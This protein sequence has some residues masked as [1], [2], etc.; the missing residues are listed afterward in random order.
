VNHQQA[1]TAIHLAWRATEAIIDHLAAR[2]GRDEAARADE[3][4]KRQLVA[5]ELVSMRAEL[6]A[7][8]EL[9]AHAKRVGKN[10]K[11][12]QTSSSPTLDEALAELFAAEAIQSVM[13]RIGSRVAH[14]GLEATTLSQNLHSLAIATFIDGVLSPENYER[15]AD[16]LRSVGHAGD[17]GLD[18]EQQLYRE[19]FKRYAEEVVMPLADKIHR[20]DTDIPAAIIDGLRELGCFGLSIP[21]RYGGAQDDARPNHM[22]M[23][24]VTEELSRASLGAAGSLITRP[25]IVAKAILTGGAEAQKQKWLP[26]IASGEKMVA[27]AVTEPDFGSDVAG[28]K[29]S[30]TPVSGGYLVNGTKT[31][32]TFG[33]YADLLLVLARTDPDLSK[34]HRGLSLLLVEKSRCAGH[35]FEHRQPER[36]GVIKGAAMRT[37]GYRGMHSFEINFVDYFVPE[38]NLI[39]GKDGLGKGFYLQ[40]AGFASGRLQTAA[41]ANGV[42]QAALEKCLAYAKDR[43]VFGRPIFDY[44]LTKVKIA[45]MAAALQA[46]RQFTYAAARLMDQQKGQMEASLVKF[47]ASK[48]AEWITREAVQIH[49]GM[50]YAEEMSVSRYFV[51]ARVFSI[52]EGAEEVLALKV[53]ARHLIEERAKELKVRSYK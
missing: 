48:M 51:D 49:G 50:G 41:R 11:S 32:C 23:V 35:E 24:I 33:G 46:S 2:L 29:V 44:Q 37:I 8:V 31:W 16:L 5:Y 47:F 36:N 19:T 14:F 52:F 53:I 40:M 10:H 12:S 25:E 45:R 39:G 26:L 28:M 43:I 13:A 1:E 21:A 18:E 9:L 17:F 27:V 42:M 6:G 3:L 38:E 15:V 20:E 30:A 34:R 22:G 7:A 4:D